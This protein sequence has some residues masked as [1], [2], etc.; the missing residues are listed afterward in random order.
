[1]GS[2]NLFWPS[3]FDVLGRP[4]S[5]VGTATL[6]TVPSGPNTCSYQGTAKGPC[7]QLRD[8]S[9][10]PGQSFTVT[11][12]VTTPA[13]QQGSWLSPGCGAQAGEQLQRFAWQ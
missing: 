8:L 3:G 2:A 6:D 1:M 13:C 5:S 12:T 10:A 4:T 7:V 9:L 11:M